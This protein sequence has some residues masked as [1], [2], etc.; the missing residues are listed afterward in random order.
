MTK[1]NILIKGYLSSESNG[2]TCPSIVLVQNEN[3]NIVIDP[4]TT[5]N[6]KQIV[7]ALKKHNLTLKDINLVFLTHCHYD[8]I[9]NIAIFPKA[10]IMDFWAKWDNDKDYPKTELGKDIKI[11]KTPGHSPD[12]QTMLVKTKNGLIA[13]C[14][15]VFWKENFPK[16]DSYANDK[17]ALEKSR[18]KILK[19][20]DYI[21]PGH[22]KM[23]RVKK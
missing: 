19:L 6:P 20:A 13:I 22:G 21:I 16:N 2:R 17:K 5:K 10:K 7:S 18:E 4:G 23:F 14:G 11:I 3:N 12:N 8:H 15:D 9:R 1:V